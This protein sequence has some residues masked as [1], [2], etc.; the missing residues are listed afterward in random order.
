M[1]ILKISTAVLFHVGYGKYKKYALRISKFPLV[2]HPKP[3]VMAV[4]QVAFISPYNYEIL[5]LTQ[6]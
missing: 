4:G 3:L 6:I 5:Y 2:L 1:N